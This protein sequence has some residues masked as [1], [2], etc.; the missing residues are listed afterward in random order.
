MQIPFI[1]ASEEWLVLAIDLAGT[2]R[3]MLL[4]ALLVQLAAS[5]AGAG[6]PVTVAAAVAREL[7]LPLRATSA[8]PGQNTSLP[9]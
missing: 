5:V 2:D 3:L 6:V 4:T 9:C 8:L 1:P 7:D